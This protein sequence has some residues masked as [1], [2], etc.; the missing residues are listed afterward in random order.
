MIC[1]LRTLVRLFVCLLAHKAHHIMSVHGLSFEP[2][3]LKNINTFNAV[4][5]IPRKQLAKKIFEIV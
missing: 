2:F 1:F 4:I 5:N 3:V